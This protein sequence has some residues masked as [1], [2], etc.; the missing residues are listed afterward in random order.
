LS[1]LTLSGEERNM[2]FLLLFLQLFLQSN[3]SNHVKWKAEI[4]AQRYILN[5]GTLKAVGLLL[6]HQLFEC[7]QCFCVYLKVLSFKK[8]SQ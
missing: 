5:P 3:I 4:S 6:K 8:L 1:L 7:E 2:H